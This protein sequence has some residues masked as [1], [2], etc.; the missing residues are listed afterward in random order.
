M[1]FCWFNN[2]RL[3]YQ[4]VVVTIPL[5]THHRLINTKAQRYNYC[6]HI[7]YK[8]A[9]PR[10]TLSRPALGNRARHCHYS[11]TS[12]TWMDED[13]SVERFRTIV[14]LR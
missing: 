13:S 12:P 11:V 10:E 6:K 1:T 9:E 8:Y 2:N 14:Q 4:Y 3:G 5:D 7:V